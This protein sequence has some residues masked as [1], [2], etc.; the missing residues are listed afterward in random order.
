M[1]SHAAIVVYDKT[2]FES[3]ERVRRFI[4]T[5]REQNEEDPVVLVVGNKL[6][7]ESSVSSEQGMD[8]AS[9]LGALFMEVSGKTGENIEFCFDTVVRACLN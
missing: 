7:L 9:S 4:N 3:F 6:D 2:C 1:N 5:F 8:L